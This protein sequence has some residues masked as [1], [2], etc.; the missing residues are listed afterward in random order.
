VLA[1]YYSDQNQLAYFGTLGAVAIVVG[2]VLVILTPF[3]R[4]QMSGVR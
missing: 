3:I 4:K 1:G 2:A